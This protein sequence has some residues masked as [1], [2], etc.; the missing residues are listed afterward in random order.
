MRLAVQGGYIP[1]VLA[2]LVAGEQVNCEAGLM[3]YSD[4]SVTFAQRPLTQGGLGK[5]MRRTLVGGIPFYMHSYLGP[6]A[7]AFSRAGPGEV[8]VLELAAGGSLDVAEH[9][10]LLASES[11]GYDTTYVAGTGRIGR[12]IGF[13]MDRL[14]GPGTVAVHGHGNILSF[15]LGPEELFDIDHGAILLKD[16]SVTMQAFNQPVGGGLLGHAMSYEALRVRGPGRLWLQT[17]DP[18]LPRR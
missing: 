16:A 18:S 1:N 14:T 4:P 8:R 9:S 13:W 12:L 17:L 3:V 2:E 5:A 15:N 11:I 10:L 7:V 6:G